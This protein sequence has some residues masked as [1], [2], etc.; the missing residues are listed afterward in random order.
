MREKYENRGSNDKRK[1]KLDKIDAVRSRF[2][3]TAAYQINLEGSQEEL[4]ENTS[5]RV[6]WQKTCDEL[7]N[8]LEVDGDDAIEVM[9]LINNPAVAKRIVSTSEFKDDLKVLEKTLARTTQD[10]IRGAPGRLSNIVASP[11]FSAEST[12]LSVAVDK[13]FCS[14]GKKHIHEAR[15]HRHGYPF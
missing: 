7:E 13:N 1:A 12:V 4:D 8:C 9:N 14:D 2:L 5:L 15:K 10:R 3:T 6:R 11:G